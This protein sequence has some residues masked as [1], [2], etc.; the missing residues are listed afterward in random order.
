MNALAHF[1]PHLKTD[2][3]GKAVARF[4]LPDSLTKYRVMV[5]A[6]TLDEFGIGE[7]SILA[8]L[9]LM[10]KHSPPRFLNFGD[11]CTFPVIVQ[12]ECDEEKEV[13]VGLRGTNVSIANPGWKLKVAARGR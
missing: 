13:I 1:G 2:E 4:T 3:I 7:T 10:V 11:E 9:P 8:T 6:N 12:N 5:V